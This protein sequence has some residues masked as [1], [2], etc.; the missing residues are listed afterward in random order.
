MNKRIESR[1]IMTEDRIDSDLPK[2]V[3][4]RLN[5]IDNIS[6]G[7]IRFETIENVVVPLKR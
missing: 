7:K 2:Q 5:D 4:K 3:A 6:L 1:P